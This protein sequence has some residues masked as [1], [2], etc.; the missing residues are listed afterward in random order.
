MAQQ[1]KKQNA[2]QNPKVL[3]AQYR[4]DFFRKMKLIIDCVC[5]KDIFP[6]IPSDFLHMI[7][8]CRC[9]PF[10]IL[11]ENGSNI[12]A[13]Y[14]RDIRVIL[15]NVMR[16]QLITISPL[17]P[18]I[19]LNDFFTVGLTI[20]ILNAH[21]NK[22]SFNH[23]DKVKEALTQF[24]DAIVTNEEAN[25]RLFDSLLAHNLGTSD[26]REVLYWLKHEMVFPKNNFGE[27]ENILRINTVTP[28]VINVNVEGNSRPAIRVGWALSFSGA[29]W[30]DIKPSDLGFKNA[31]AEIP[32]NVYMQ[33]HALNRL[34]ERIDCFWAG[35]V[36]YNMFC[37]LLDPKI[38]YDSNKNL[39]IEYYIFNTK[40]GYFRADIVDGIILLRTFLFVTNNGTPEGQLL[41]KNTGLQKMDKMYLSIDKL[42]TFMNSDLDKN[43]EVQRLFKNS[44]CQCLID[45]YNNMKPLL[46]KT[47]NDFHFDLMLSY[48]N[49]NSSN[50]TTDTAQVALQLEN[51]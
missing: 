26:L 25:S 36:Q 39:L 35:I 16:K 11:P 42:S 23:A 10:K 50:T 27:T 30:V 44:G 43:D 40:A 20:P 28:E 47:D 8:L 15:P 2:R 46:T 12:P 29:L 14:L 4:N 33:Q 5:G 32:L 49:L 37:S 45:L 6:L 48:L 17:A 38:A 22:T 21:I 3:A 31:F 51:D 41:E 34:M 24:C 7:Y 9:T 1:K 18:K 13:R 19:T